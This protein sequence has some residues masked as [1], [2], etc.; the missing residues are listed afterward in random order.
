MFKKFMCFL[1]VLTF[2]STLPNQHSFAQSIDDNTLKTILVMGDSLS[3]GYNLPPGTSFPSKL[4]IWLNNNGHTVKVINAGVSGDTSAGGLA[5][6]DW[7]LAGIS[8]PPDLV[9]VEFGGNDALRGIEPA[10]TTA[11][12][13]EMITTLKEKQIPT[14]LMGMKAPPNM[15]AHYGGQF[16]GLFA[17]LAEKHSIPLYP[18]FLDG[19]A[20]IPHL[21]L[22]D[23][24][25]P[26]EQ[27]VDIIVSKLG[28]LVA[29]LIYAP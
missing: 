21:N 6:L 15:G 1:V 29:E 25:H 22:I 10:N 24:I 16:D 5:R 18:F 20:A 17:K 26:N 3:A 4:Q 14:Y 13:D 12:L 9:I 2:F 7:A 11:N 28:P 27:G 23:G 8:N 19:V